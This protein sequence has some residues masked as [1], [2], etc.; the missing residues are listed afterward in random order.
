MGYDVAMMAD[1]TSRWVHTIK[2]SGEEMECRPKPCERSPVVWERCPVM[3]VTQP[4]WVLVSPGS[5][6][7]LAVSRVLEETASVSFFNNI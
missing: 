3:L 5:T 4:T 2:K 6:S 7:A 1:S